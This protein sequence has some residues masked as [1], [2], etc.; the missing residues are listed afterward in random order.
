VALSNYIE[1]QAAVRT[2]M[3]GVSTGGLSADA[4]TDAIARAEA[5][6]NRRTRLREA[7]QIATATYQTSSKAIEDRRVEL[8]TGYV[9]FLD[10]RWKKA[11]QADTA[12][13]DAIYVSPERIHEYYDRTEALWYTLRAQL[14]FNRHTNGEEYELMMHYFKKWDIATNSTNWILTNYPDAYL[15]GSCME[16]AIHMRDQTAAVAYRALFDQALEELNELSERGRDD[17][18]ADI[19]DLGMLSHR[20]EFNILTS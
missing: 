2:E 16:T 19:S 20:G 10:L 9:E 13:T 8:P 6:I 17:S 3:G 4:L 12:Y 15:Y 14:E 7:E 18:I 1:L 5:K 11:S